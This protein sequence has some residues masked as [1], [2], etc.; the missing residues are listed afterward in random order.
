M[1]NTLVFTRMDR[2]RNASLLI[3][4]SSCVL[5]GMYWFRAALVPFVIAM[6]L[7]FSIAPLI[8]WQRKKLKFPRWIATI[9]TG[10]LALLLFAAMWSI[11]ISSLSQ[12]A[13]HSGEYQRRFMNV[14]DNTLDAVPVADV[15]MSS[16]DLR[17]AIGEVPSHTTDAL[18]PNTIGTIVD[19]LS[20]G[21]LVFLFLLFMVMG[22]GI[23]GSKE[24]NVLDDIERSVQKYMNLKFLLSFATGFLTWLVL[25]LLGIEFAMVFGVLAFMLNFI[26]NVGSVMANVIP[27]PVI[28][29]GDHSTT[30]MVLA[31][32]IPIAIQFTI[33]NILEPLVF[34][35]ALKIHPVVVMLT[36]ALF[37]V[38]WGIP[39]MFLAT[40]MTAVLKILLE[41]RISTRPLAKLIE[42][43]LSAL[44]HMRERKPPGQH[45]READP[46]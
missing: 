1:R 3:L 6:F 41:R 27:I 25:W 38:V 39:G 23:G 14:L 44:G 46:I 26:P 40:P 7:Y 9:T 34:G 45:A 36:L 16:D 4:A 33:G 12:V 15:G 20:Q 19:L 42:G 32:G 13:E 2:V 5:A 43:D 11:I 17:A 30:V 31:I 24:H 21:A 37:G 28:V 8:T 35:D 18:F 10:A 29:I 22:K